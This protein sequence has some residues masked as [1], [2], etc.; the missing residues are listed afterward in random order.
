MAVLLIYVGGVNYP[1]SKMW[2]KSGWEPNTV[3]GIIL[4]LMKY[5]GVVLLAIG[6]AQVTGIHQ[7]FRKRWQELRSGTSQGSE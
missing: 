1:E 6:V 2:N 4:W 7:K 5:M 3:H